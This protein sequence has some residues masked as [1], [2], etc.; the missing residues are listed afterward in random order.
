MLQGKVLILELVSINRLSTGSIVVGEI[1]TL[2]HEVGD[3]PVEGGSLVSKS[4]LSSAQSTEVL[5]SLR[6]NISTELQNITM[7][8]IENNSLTH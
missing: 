7:V 5:G 4:L 2:A 8:K 3:D 6:D 1:S